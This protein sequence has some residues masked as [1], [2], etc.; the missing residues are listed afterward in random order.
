MFPKAHATAYVTSA[1]RVAWFKVHMPIYYYAAYFSIR[2]SQFDIASMIG[3][4]DAIRAK[5]DE[6]EAKGD[7]ASNKDKE[8]CSVLYSAL[9]M[10]AR[11]FYFKNIDVS[12]SD[13]KYFKITEDKK[14]LLLPFRALDGLGDAVADAIVKARKTGPFVSKEDLRERGKINYSSLQKLEKLGCLNNLS[15]SNQL[16]LF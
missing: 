5:I 15:D 16:S 9:E 7:D 2:C 13:G 14:G 10:T 4:A 6:L 1:F 12:E 3:G 8:V 11:G